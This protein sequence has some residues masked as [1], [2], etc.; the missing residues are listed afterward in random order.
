MVTLYN[1][2]LCREF[3]VEKC[4]TPK[5]IISYTKNTDGDVITKITTILFNIINNPGLYQI[6]RETKENPISILDVCS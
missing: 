2:F 5:D 4:R 6:P 3:C 1:N